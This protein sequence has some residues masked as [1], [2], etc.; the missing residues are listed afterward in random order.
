LIFFH[1]H[2]I[3]HLDISDGNLVSKTID[4]RRLFAFIDFEC[5]IMYGADEPG[6]LTTTGMVATH[7]APEQDDSI[8]YDPFKADV[9]QLGQL[10]E[11]AMDVSLRRSKGSQRL[12][13][14]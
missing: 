8:P 12:T 2:R 13:I 1:S 6:P 9:W 5:A 11:R 7:P 3:A 14:E 10:F 4:G